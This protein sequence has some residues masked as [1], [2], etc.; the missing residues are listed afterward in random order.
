[1]LGGEI[2]KLIGDMLIRGELK[3]PGF[4]DRLIGINDVDVSGDGSYATV[5]L[6]AIG[7]D[8]KE[9]SEAEKNGIVEAFSRRRGFL[10][11]EIGKAVKLR[12]VPDLIFKLDSSYEYGLK[13]DRLIDSLNIEKED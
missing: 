2:Q 3:D 8:G 10:R 7:R 13:M 11:T 4:K 9:L 12:H 5:Y 6:T 1:M